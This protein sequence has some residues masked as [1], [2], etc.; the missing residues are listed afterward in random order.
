MRQWMRE[1]WVIM[2]SAFDYSVDDPDVIYQLNER[3]KV[4]L[5]LCVTWDPAVKII[6]IGDNL[7]WG[8]D[9][10][11]LANARHFEYNESVNT[12]KVLDQ[13]ELENFGIE[14][15]DDNMEEDEEIEVE[16]DMDALF[17]G[18][19]EIDTLA[20]EFANL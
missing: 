1:E 14:E 6:P 15:I 4:V 16:D 19:L 13:Q 2:T 7:P 11:D 10:A 9:L 20:Y 12:E 3:R 5:R 17:I 18:E 8:P